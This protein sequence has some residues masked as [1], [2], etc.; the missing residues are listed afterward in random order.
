MNFDWPA[1]YH[2]CHRTSE[3]AGIFFAHRRF[4][5]VMASEAVLTFGMVPMLV[6]T[7][8]TDAPISVA[9]MFKIQAP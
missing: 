3:S 4:A 5:T 9:M 1:E 2:A 6:L 7:Q 8:T